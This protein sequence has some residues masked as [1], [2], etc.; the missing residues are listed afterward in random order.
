M[1]P[2]LF[3]IIIKKKKM[4]SFWLRIYSLCSMYCKKNSNLI[5]IPYWLILPDSLNH[6]NYRPILLFNTDVKT[7]AKILAN[8][9]YTFISFIIPPVFRWDSVILYIIIHLIHVLN[10][11]RIPGFLISSDLQNFRARFKIYFD[12]MELRDSFLKSIS[13]FKLNPNC[14]N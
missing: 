3:I 10:S 14:S 4:S 13:V 6:N 7:L 8:R 9:I 12:Q 11:R 2:W 1:T 5:P